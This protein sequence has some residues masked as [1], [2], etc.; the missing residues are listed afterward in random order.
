MD[1]KS[2]WNLTKSGSQ[3]GEIILFLLEF[4][5][6]LCIFVTKIE[7]SNHTNDTLIG[8]ALGGQQK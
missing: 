6:D 4:T 7:E 5:K 8:S 1:F 2:S 3:I